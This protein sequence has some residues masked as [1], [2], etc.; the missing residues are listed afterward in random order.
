MKAFN[1]YFQEHCLY[2]TKMPIHCFSKGAECFELLTV[3]QVVNDVMLLIG[4]T[5][6]SGKLGTAKEKAVPSYCF[7]QF[8]ISVSR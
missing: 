8:L 5:H 6:S 1:R 2:Y 4:T 3:Q 7:Q